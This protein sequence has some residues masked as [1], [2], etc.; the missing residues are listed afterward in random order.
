MKE[1][2]PDRVRLGIF[3]VDLRA[4]ELREGERIVR[5]QEQPFQILLMLI[6]RDGEIVTRDEIQKKLWPNDTVRRRE[7]VHGALTVDAAG[8]GRSI[9]VSGRVE[10]QAASR[11]EP[12][13][14]VIHEHMERRLDPGAG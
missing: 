11:A 2:L 14:A 9:D 5:P 8:V 12:I 1:T 7:L 4:G 6:A 10:D 3:E 13:N